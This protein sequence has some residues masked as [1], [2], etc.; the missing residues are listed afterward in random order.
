VDLS[1]PVEVD[2][3]VPTDAPDPPHATANIPQ[4]STKIG[5]GN[6]ATRIGKLLAAIFDFVKVK[7]AGSI[8]S[9]VNDQCHKSN[10]MITFYPTDHCSGRGFVAISRRVIIA[11][12]ASQHS[13]RFHDSL[14]L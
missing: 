13:S 5:S 10:P 12:C 14:R 2:W 8:A 11:A 3:T 7:E 4:L 6:N 1:P 9:R